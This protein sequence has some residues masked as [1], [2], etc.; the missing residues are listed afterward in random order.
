MKKR[1]LICLLLCALLLLSGCAK[2]TVLEKA[3]QTLP[4]PNYP[5]REDAVLSAFTDAGYGV[6]LDSN[7]T[8]ETSDRSSIVLRDKEKTYTEGGN[9]V[10]VANVISAN[11]DQGRALSLS[12]FGEEGADKPA[13]LGRILPTPNAPGQRVFSR[14]A[15]P[16]FLEIRQYSCGK[17]S[18]SAQ[19]LLAAGHIGS[20]QIHPRRLE[21]AAGIGRDV[22][23]TG[24]RGAL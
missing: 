3:E 15:A 14:C 2:E 22:L 10:L 19:K 21:D 13:N 17:M 1:G 8:E 20:F 24:K 9:Y 11:T 7:D 18:C 6:V 16:F 5:L 23:R 4:I 12:F